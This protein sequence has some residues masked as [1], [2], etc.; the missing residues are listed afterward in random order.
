MKTLR[1]V[2][3]PVLALVMLACITFGGAVASANPAPGETSSNV[4][5]GDGFF[6]LHPHL[7]Q[8]GVYGSAEMT[9][10][11]S[12][13]YTGHT[14][15]ELDMFAAYIM[16][17]MDYY[18]ATGGENGGVV[19]NNN[20]I[21]AL[22]W[23]MLCTDSTHMKY[24]FHLS[25]GL[26]NAQVAVRKP[27]RKAYDAYV[28]ANVGKV[29]GDYTMTIWVSSDPAYQDI[30]ELRLLEKHGTPTMEKKVL[31]RNDTV[32]TFDEAMGWQ[33]G[34]DYDIGDVVPFQIT[35]TLSDMPNFKE[36]YLE[37]WDEMEHLTYVENSLKVEMDGKD[38]TSSFVFEKETTG[39]KTNMRIYCD[40]ILPLG[41][42][43]GSKFVVTYTATLNQDAIIGNPGNPNTA[44]LIYTRSSGSAD[45]GI[46]KPDTVKV[47]TYRLIA[48]KV[49]S[50]LR[51]LTGAAFK[52]SKLVKKD[53]G[54]QEYVTVAV[55]GATETMVD[56]KLV[57]TLTEPNRTEFVWNGID[58]GSYKIEEVVTP[59]G[60]NT[61]EPIEFWVKAEHDHKAEDPRLYYASSSYEF[62]NAYLLEDG[63]RIFEFDGDFKTPIVNQFGAVLPS[64]GGAGTKLIY[65][66][67]SILALG[68][69]VVLIAKKRIGA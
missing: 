14:Q 27:I 60:Y 3:L 31:D 56:G 19:I 24:E 1:K 15:D 45:K 36:Y 50:D 59:V 11:P 26:D 2:V 10:V 35:A 9:A 25:Y 43:K 29:R 54:T 46:T 40:N 65:I 33:D 47:F 63:Y 20:D 68:A 49:D 34:A 66:A 64:T 5:F 38:V 62:E 12:T 21:Q 8:P 4:Y 52:L 32:N 41:A 57:Y 6:C 13:E 69:G 7:L 58:D 53:D 42:K 61:M 18:Y 37:F 28:R 44:K 51:P 22:I 48:D 23:N 55:I 30:L 17:Q 39:F 16:L 67:G